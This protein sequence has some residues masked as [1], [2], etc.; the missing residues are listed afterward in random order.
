[1]NTLLSGMLAF[2]PKL[3]SDLTYLSNASQIPCKCDCSRSCENEFYFIKMLRYRCSIQLFGVPPKLSPFPKEGGG[4]WRVE[5]QGG[6]HIANAF[7]K[8]YST[9]FHGSL[10]VLVSS[11]PMKVSQGQIVTKLSI[12]H[13][14]Y[15]R[16]LTPIMIHQIFLVARDWS[17]RST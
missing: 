16:E 11:L 8:R 13:C 9:V 14:L 12:L 15:W 6:R 2:I 4:F 5:G 17:K 3:S 1:M 7:L 10:S